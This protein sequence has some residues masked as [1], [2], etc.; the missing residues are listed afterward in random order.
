M[1][2]FE[3]K[4]KGEEKRRMVRGKIQMKRIENDTS[5]QVTFSKRRNGLLKKAYELSVLCDAEVALIVFSPRGKLYEFANPS[6]QKMLERY[7]KCSEGSNTT[8]T[9]KEQDIQYL[10]REIA[11]ME[12]RIKILESRQRKMVGEELASCA[13][14]DLNMLESQVERGLRHIR[15]RKTQI[16]V[17]EIEELKRKERISSEE[18]AFHR[19][20]FVDPLYE[21]GS[22]LATLASGLGSIQNSEVE[23]QLVIR[24]PSTKNLTCDYVNLV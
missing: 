22:V 24:P 9:T 23:T 19:K 13:L 17:D 16:L 8:N 7:G 20:R 1:E 11:N 18:N 12:E 21:N 4:G 2:C 14:N 3:E 6:M 15:A 5:R 10:K